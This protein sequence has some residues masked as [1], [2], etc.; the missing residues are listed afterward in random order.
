MDYVAHLTSL[1]VFLTWL[2]VVS[3]GLF[4]FLAYKLKKANKKLGTLSLEQNKKW[5]DIE[6]HAQQEAQGIIET[7]NKRASEITLKAIDVNTQ[8]SQKLQETIDAMLTSQKQAL[9][10]ASATVLKT[11]RE[12]VTQLNNHIL[13]VSTN[14]YKDID[15]N[16]RADMH[17]FLELMK[18]QTFE[19]EKFAEARIKE[20]YDKLEKEIYRRR[21][22]KIKNLDENI[23]KILSNISKDII[24]KSLDLSSQE[25]L[26]IKSLDQAK[27]EGQI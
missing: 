25:E 11:H 6:A 9:E 16:S 7:A 20:E 12:Q 14:I 27:K 8:S 10:S 5:Q 15:T 21:E 22:E 24:G 18:K 17:A 19:A 23:Y 2:S 26:I 1:N 3:L 13:E 4:I